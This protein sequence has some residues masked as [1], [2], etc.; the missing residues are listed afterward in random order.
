MNKKHKQTTKA[1]GMVLKGAIISKPEEVLMMKEEALL[2]YN[3]LTCNV[4]SF[5]RDRDWVSTLL[6]SFLFFPMEVEYQSVVAIPV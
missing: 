4:V 1:T 3:T 5:Y 6:A 2:G